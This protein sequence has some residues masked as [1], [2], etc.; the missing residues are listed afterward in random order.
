M[1]FRLEEDPIGPETQELA[2]AELR[3]TEE[4]KKNGIIELKKL[5]EGII[6]KFLFNLMS[7]D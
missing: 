6:T 3:E 5:L 4:N 7:D 1:A 2:V